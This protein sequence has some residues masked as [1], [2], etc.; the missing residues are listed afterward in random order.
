MQTIDI[1]KINRE[2]FRCLVDSLSRPSKITS[3]Q[4][5]YDSYLFAMASVL[6]YPE[7][8]YCNAT[9]Q[10]FS[11][12]DIATNTKQALPKEADYI[13]FDDLASVALE[14]IKKGTYIDPDFS[15]TLIY[16]YDNPMDEVLLELTGAGIKEKAQA[17]YP[18][19]KEFAY[20]L[21]R[22]NNNFPLGNEIF[23]INTNSGELK[24]LSRTTQIKVL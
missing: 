2:N 13:F 9:S 8:S 7:V 17:L 3:L 16:S 1:E 24:A 21:S 11:N 19:T 22:Q 14:Q 6:L 10:D 20:S 18:V 23:F 15:A 5:M 12:I 4:K